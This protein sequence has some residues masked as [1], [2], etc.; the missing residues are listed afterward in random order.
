MDIRDTSPF[1]RALA[2]V[3]AFSEK[4][5]AVMPETA[6]KE[7]ISYVSSITGEDAEKLARLYEI[8][9][10]AGRL[11]KFQQPLSTAVAGFAEE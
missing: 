1:S 2:Q 7:L 8:F 6:S 11:D 4:G 9:L 10:S 3:E 5:V